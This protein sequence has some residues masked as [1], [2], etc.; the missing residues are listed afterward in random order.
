MNKKQNLLGVH[1]SVAGDFT[2]GI[3][4]GQQLG[5]T[6]IQIFTKNNRQWASKKITDEQAHLFIQA[7]QNSSIQTVVVHASYLINLASEKPE[8]AEKSYLAL[9]DEINRCHQLNSKFLILHPGTNPDKQ[10]AVQ[11]IAHLIQKALDQTAQTNV[12][13]LVETMAGQG[14]SCATT[15]EELGQI[16]N[17][18]TTKHRIGV[19]FDTCHVFAAGY[20]LNTKYDE[21]MH[22]FDQT[23]G[24]DYI[25]VIHINN[26][27]KDC[28]SRVDRH[29]H[30]KTGVINLQVFRNIMNN[31]RFYHIAKILETPKS[32]E[33]DFD[34]E[35]MKILRSFIK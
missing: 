11:Q 27:K 13:V 26:S 29:E 12:S 21:V 35:N 14:N 2:N 34:A 4:V 23:V 22:A 30:I 17:L 24:L 28:N 8:L 31:Q 10:F 32:D 3:T 1:V 16:L 6:A 19:C 5:C 20:D 7:Q 9:V 33:F 18:I 25:K 15:F